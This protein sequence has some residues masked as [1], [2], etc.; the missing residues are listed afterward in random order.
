MEL[1]LQGS[2]MSYPRRGNFYIHSLLLLDAFL[3]LAFQVS[4]AK[5]QKQF[6]NLRKAKKASLEAY[7]VWKL[8]T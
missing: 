6:S 1:L 5:N 8:N 3:T 7:F 2:C 4:T